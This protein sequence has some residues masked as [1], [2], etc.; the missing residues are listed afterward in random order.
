MDEC[1]LIKPDLSYQEEIQAFRLEMLL[2]ESAMDG[3]GQL[4]R[5]SNIEDWL[6][7]NHRF[8]H[9]ATVPNHFVPAE[10]FIYVR[11]TDQTI[12][13]MVQFRHELNDLLR[14][15]GGHIGYSIRPS[16]RQKGYAKRMLGACLEVCQ[17]QELQKVLVTCKEDNEAS[18]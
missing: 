5:M 7:F 10:Q 14:N 18:R 9:E 16:E 1:I 3:T 13:G 6:D 15:F 17:K 2:S 4:R 12:V 8:E 11:K